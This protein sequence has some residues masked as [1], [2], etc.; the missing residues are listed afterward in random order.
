MRSGDWVIFL[1]LG[2]VFVASG[3]ALI[4]RRR[5]AH[6]FLRAGSRRAFGTKLRTGPA[7]LLAVGI[8]W[9]AMGAAAIVI[10]IISGLG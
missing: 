9:I 5:D 8:G 6:R 7:V 1:L 3:V 2:S 10:G 4:L